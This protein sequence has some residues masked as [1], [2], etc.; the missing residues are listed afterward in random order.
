M[1]QLDTKEKRKEKNTAYEL[2]QDMTHDGAVWSYSAIV[3]SQ[4]KA[5]QFQETN[6]GVFPLPAA[7]LGL[8]TPSTPHAA[9]PP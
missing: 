4:K 8:P 6:Y 3:E 1:G 9:H 7:L 5:W 2:G